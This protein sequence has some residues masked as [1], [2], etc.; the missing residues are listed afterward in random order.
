[1]YIFKFERRYLFLNKALFRPICVLNNNF[2]TYTFGLY[3]IFIMPKLVSVVEVKYLR[4]ELKM[5]LKKKFECYAGLQMSSSAKLC[6]IC[7]LLSSI[8][9]LTTQLPLIQA[10]AFSNPP[11]FLKVISPQSWKRGIFR[12]FHNECHHPLLLQH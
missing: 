8:E 3:D 10:I 7:M 2:Y 5:P 9:L 4:T 6:Y 11:M 12:N 1:M